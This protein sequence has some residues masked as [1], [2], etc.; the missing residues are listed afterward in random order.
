MTNNQVSY[1]VCQQYVVFEEDWMQ[2]VVMQQGAGIIRL[3][4]S[5]WM[6]WYA[7]WCSWHASIDQEVPDKQGPSGYCCTC[8]RLRTLNQ[9]VKHRDVARLIPIHL[10]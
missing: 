10:Q 8:R 9:A 7:T 3:A 1:Y 2:G 5:E 4:S 6:H